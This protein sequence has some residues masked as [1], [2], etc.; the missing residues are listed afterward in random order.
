MNDFTRAFGEFQ[1]VTKRNM[2]VLIG[3]LLVGDVYEKLHSSNYEAF[4]ETCKKLCSVGYYSTIISFMHGVFLSGKAYDLIEM[5]KILDNINI[6]ED[7]KLSDLC[8]DFYLDFHKSSVFYHVGKYK[9]YDFDS[10]DLYRGDAEKYG[11][12]LNDD[13]NTMKKDIAEF[14]LRRLFN[15]NVSIE[16]IT[17]Q[18]IDYIATESNMYKT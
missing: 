17:R 18:D 1:S 6:R 5:K 14:L 9:G 8:A 4:K 15:M 13:P 16:N 12:D 11:L 10:I 3:S 2:K 7:I